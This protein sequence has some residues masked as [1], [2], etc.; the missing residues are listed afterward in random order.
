MI[1]QELFQYVFGGHADIDGYLALKLEK[2]KKYVKSDQEVSQIS[3]TLQQEKTRLLKKLND[4][5]EPIKSNAGF[6]K[7][8]REIGAHHLE[9]NLYGNHTDPII[10]NTTHFL[11]SEETYLPTYIPIN[12][13]NQLPQLFFLCKLVADYFEKN[14]DEY[15]SVARLHAF[16]IALLFSK[17]S[18]KETIEAF[19][20]YI[21]TH[22]YSHAA[23]P[24][25]DAL[26]YPE[27][28]PEDRSYWKLDSLPFWQQ[29]IYKKGIVAAKLF[30]LAIAIE[31]KLERSPKDFQEA[32]NT[33][34]MITYANAS[35]Y[36]ELADLCI[37]YFIDENTFD[38][39]LE[40]EKNRK[41]EDNLPEVI[42]DSETYC[43]YP[44]Y[45]LIKLPID[46]PRAYILG[47]I[48]KCCQSIGAHSEKCV[49]D[50][51]TLKNNGF[52]V[53]LKAKNKSESHSLFQ[54][55][56]KIDYL[57]YTIIG[58]G[59]AWL[60]ST[61]N[62]TFDSW[63]N[64]HQGDNDI[65][66]NLLTAFAEQVTKK[67]NIL[68]VT[69]G[70][71]GKTPKKFKER[72]IASP[73]EKILEGHQYPDS[74]EQ[75]I[76]YSNKE[77]IE[78]LRHKLLNLLLRESKKPNEYLHRFVDKI[79]LHSY[80]DFE[81]LFAL[82][83]HQYAHDFIING[84]CKTD[85]EDPNYFILLLD[86][87]NEKEKIKLI[88]E[89]RIKKS[90]LGDY[91]LNLGA[92]SSIFSTLIENNDLELAH[93]LFE[94]S[95]KKI[96]PEDVTYVLYKMSNKA[97]IHYIQHYLNKNNFKNY[98]KNIDDL[99]K[100]NGTING[101][102]FQELIEA[103]Y[104][105]K[106]FRAILDETD[107]SK[108][109]QILPKENKSLFLTRWIGKENVE[110]CL[111]KSQNNFFKLYH[112]IGESAGFLFNFIESSCFRQC[113]KSS[114]E[115][116]NFIE[117]FKFFK[118][119][120]ELKATLDKI[121]GKDFICQ[122]INGKYDLEKVIDALPDNLIIY[123]LENILGV[124][125]VN[126][127]LQG[128]Y[129]DHL[130]LIIKILEK[131]ND[132]DKMYFLHKIIYKNNL[133]F[134]I[135]TY[136][137]DKFHLKINELSKLLKKNL[138]SLF[139]EHLAVKINKDDSLFKFN[140]AL[141]FLEEACKGKSDLPDFLRIAGENVHAA[142]SRSFQQHSYNNDNLED[143]A[144][145]LHNIATAI[146]FDQYNWTGKYS[147]EKN[148][149][150]QGKQRIS[151]CVIGAITAFIGAA[152]I[153]SSITVALVSFGA[154]APISI[155]GITLGINLIAGGIAIAS[156][157]S[158]AG[159]T[160]GACLFAA[161]GRSHGAHLKVSEFYKAYTEHRQRSV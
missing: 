113:A 117:N 27:I 16:K 51:I 23:K 151:R 109:H 24:A 149:C 44:G 156:A 80:Q 131:I 64:L 115:F 135:L 118:K 83:E 116:A 54:A 55:N 32:V 50:G 46:D 153:A 147:F 89:I 8:L 107:P 70:K 145:I 128:N 10:F 108:L 72:G 160:T 154:V 15:D 93:E 88:K 30:K 33:V 4:F 63:E 114:T 157:I 98:I 111:L 139:S 17:P 13:G 143:M 39:C 87:I 137:R 127:I 20:S 144:L 90:I 14:N 49:I 37:S 134:C 81:L 7:A 66:F 52:Y 129:Y 82:F 106:E 35:L 136:E 84:S 71:G 100:I 19:S 60:S 96:K 34:K 67:G 47:H 62:L 57:H 43:G 3:Q 61:G 101:D 152:L 138:D 146:A 48:T 161:S 36:P 29:H 56:K 91:L 42:I 59:Y 97:K 41:T 45:Y 68:R 158:A 25:H 125:R 142:V 121:F 5:F 1:I 85:D 95:C 31:A 120:N 122:I 11:L 78:K 126:L 79:V 150:F 9:D 130:S 69:I 21:K 94:D 74:H 132:D 40:I 18:L 58:Q 99:I 75:Y 38:R 92:F 112:E 73:P 22:N 53:L 77:K 123:F 159:I 102:G 76:V 65:I 26:L 2:A 155:A 110:I 119:T 103:C 141:K 12:I 6:R 124:E 140:L 148:P 105:V 104:T 28:D 86:K 133:L